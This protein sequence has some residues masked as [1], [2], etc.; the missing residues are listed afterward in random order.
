MKKKIIFLS[1]FILLLAIGGI[2]IFY[3]TQTHRN[4][5][6]FADE[7]KYKTRLVPAPVDG[8]TPVDHNPYDNIAYMLWVLEHTEQYTSHTEGTAVSVGQTQ[9]IYNHRRVNGD[10]Q[11][12]DTIS[13]G[14]VSLGKQKYFL[15]NKV[16]IR[17]YISKK[18]DDITWKTDEPE[19]ITK[20][21]YKERYGWL[22]TQATAYIIC[23][24]TILEISEVTLLDNG[25]Y[26]ITLSL[27]PD[28]WYAPF[29]YQRE[30]K[31]NAS[32]VSKP[33]FSSI[34]I[35]Y[36]FNANW[37]IQ[38]V[39][40]KEKYK[41]TPKVAP[42]PVDCVTNITETFD[43]TTGEFDASA[44][45]FFNQYKDMIPVG[46]SSNSNP[47]EETPL[48]YITGSL[49]G[50]TNKEKTFD[51]TININEK[52]IKGKLLLNIS[53]L[54]SIVVKVS[55]GDLQVVY[56]ND[57]VYVDY[58]SLKLKCNIDEMNQ[59]LQPLLAEIVLGSSASSSQT[60]ALDLNKIMDDL[61]QATV[62]KTEEKIN[63]DL[64]L[65]LMGFSLPLVFDIDLNDD[66][67]DLQSIKS[68]V[69][70]AGTEIKISIDK[71]ENLQFGTIEGEYSDLKN[72]DFILKDITSILKNKKLSLA[73]SADYEDY[74]IS[75]TAKIG[76]HPND[77]I[78]INLTM[79]NEKLGLNESFIITYASSN[80]F[81]EYK[82][83]KLKLSMTD[84]IPWIKKYLP[85]AKM[86][87][88]NVD[89]V[90][91]ILSNIDFKA[92]IQQFTIQENEVSIALDLSSLIEELSIINLLAEDT[93][94]G[95]VLKT[96]MYDIVVS[97]DATTDFS[98]EFDSSDYVDMESY[99]DLVDYV[100]N[101]LGKESLGI[102]I[103]GTL[104]YDTYTIHL[105]GDINLYLKDTAYTVEGSIVVSYLDKEVEVKLIVED[106]D[107]YVSVLGY[108]IKVNLD[109]ISTTLEEITRRLGVELPKVETPEFGLE[110]ILKLLS[111]VKLDSTSVEMDLSSIFE[112]IGIVGVSYSLE[113][114]SLDVEI[115][116]SLV[117]MRGTIRPIEYKEVKVPTE[118]Y[119]EED[120][121]NVMNYVED[122]LR[123]LKN[124]YATLSFSGVYEGVEVSGSLYV[125]WKDEIRAKGR[126]T[127]IYE[128]HSITL[129]I[130]YSNETIYVGYENIKVKI[131]EATIKEFVSGKLPSKKELKVEEILGKVDEVL[132]GLTIRE[133][134]ISVVL[135]LG[136]ILEGMNEAH[137]ELK[138]T[139]AG[140]DITTDLY[141]F[142]LS[143]DVNQEDSVEVEDSEYTK[144]EGYIDLV[145]YFMSILCKES[146]GI[147]ID[148]TLTYDT[149]T[150]H[151]LGDINL[152]LKDT[153]YTVEG[154]IVVSYLDKEVEVK[155]IVED[156]DVYVSVLGYTIKVNLDTISTTLEEITRR[157]GVELPKVETPE[158]GLEEIL[159]LLSTVKLDSTSVEMDL[160]SIFEM[161]G[162]VGVS[163]SLEGTSLDVEIRNSLVSMRGTIRPIEYKEVKVPTEYYDEEDILNVMN[164]VEDILRLL[165]NQYAT[166]SFSGVYEGVEVSGSLYVEWKD[167]IRAKGRITVIY[168]GHSITLDIV[169][170]NETIYVG[171]ENIKVKISEAT[172]KEFVSG[173]LPSK[174]ELKVEEILGKVDEVLKGL[175]IRED[176]ISVVLNL[177]AILEGMNEAHIELKDTEAGF[178][179]TTDLY[180]FSL[181]VDVNQEDSVEVEDSEYTKVEG[182]IDLVEY[183]MS[184]L[185]KESLGIHID[186][187]YYLEGMPVE[188]NGML[189]LMYNT[190]T[191]RYDISINLTLEVSDILAQMK[192]YFVDNTLYIEFY[193]NVIEISASEL[194]EVIAV[195][196]EKFNLPLDNAST[197]LPIDQILEL[198]KSIYFFENSMEFDFSSYIA[199]LTKLVFVYT[200]IDDGYEFVVK[201][202]DLFDVA[203]TLGTIPYE[204]IVTPKA[205]LYKEDLYIL[206]DDISYILELVQGNAIQIE[207]PDALIKITMNGQEE[208]IKVNGTV[209]VLW[210]EEGYQISGSL[211]LDGMGI[212]AQIGIIVLNDTIY[213][214]VSN[215]TFC[216]KLNEIQDFISE[217]LE[218]LSPML[219]IAMPSMEASSFSLDMKDLG[220][221]L[222][223]RSIEA[224]LEAIVGNACAFLVSF[225]LVENGMITQISISYDD[226]VQFESPILISKSDVQQIDVPTYSLDKDAILEILTYAVEAYELSLKDEFNLAISTS[227]HT[228]GDVV[229]NIS[230]NVYIKLLENQE[231]DAHL[232]LIVYEYNQGNEV[233]WHQL[234]L[235][236]ISLTTMNTL[237]PSVGTAMM[238]GIYG[239][240]PN[241]LNAVVKVKSTY[242]GIEDLIAS[243]MQLMN[244][245]IPALSG[246]TTTSRMDI[247]SLIDYLEVA[248][249]SLSIGIE[250]NNLFA[251]MQDERQIIH[252]TLSKDT[253]S[254]LEGILVDNLYVSYTN[255]A[256]YM[257][258]DSLQVNLQNKEVNF[259]I[260]SADELAS[261]YDISEISNLFEALYY[262]ALE[263]NYEISGT[264]TLTALSI[265]N[266][267]MP[268]LFKIQ[269]DENG[270]PI[271]YA[272]LDMTNIGLGSLMMTKKHIY[273]YYKDSYVYIHRDDAK[274]ENDRKIKIHISEFMDNIVYYLMDYAMGLPESIISLINKTPE[275]DGF[276]DAAQCINNIFIGEDQFE[277]DLNLKEIAD[278][279]NL[280]KLLIR[281]A[282]VLV[283]KTD[284]EG[285]KIYV[286]MIYQIPKFEF[287]A[288]DVVNLN[289]SS[290]TLS[291]IK[292]DESGDYIAYDITLDELDSYLADFN[293]FYN[294]DEEYIYSKGAWVSNG[295]IKHNVVYSLGAIEDKVKRYAEGDLLDFPSYKDDIITVDVDG[296]TQYYKIL[297]WYEDAS[298]L[299]PVESI[300]NV[301]MGN[302]ARVF[303]AKLK[304]ITV[305]LTIASALDEEVILTYYEGY[306]FVREIESMYSIHK[307]E[308]RIYKFVGIQDESN[309]L[310][311]VN[312]LTYGNY[313]LTVAWD[314]VHYDFYAVYDGNEK[315]LEDTSEEVFLNQDYSIFYNG[316]Y[317]LYQNTYLTPQVLLSKF[318]NAFAVNEDEERFEIELYSKENTLFE[319]YD[320]VLFTTTREE[321]NS[322]DYYG[323]YIEKNKETDVSSLLPNGVWETF[324]INAWIEDTTYYSLDDI[325]HMTG[326]HTFTSYISTQLSYFDFE[327]VSTGASI[328]G[329]TGTSSTVIF[330]EYA[331]LSGYYRKVVEIK[332]LLDSNQN[333][334]S[335]FTENTTISTLIMNESLAFIGRNAFKNCDGL[336]N[337]Y[338]PSALEASSVASDAF[339]F[340]KTGT[341]NFEKARDI[342]KEITFHC[343]LKQA[344]ELDL[345]ACTYNGSD[346][347]YGKNEAGFLG[348]G[349]ANL[350]NSFA[351]ETICIADISNE[352]IKNM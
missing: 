296:T 138:D 282:S 128:G 103:D 61:N 124:Q 80:I 17:D 190:T 216:F 226:T 184:I 280:G 18:G 161:I 339:Y 327:I 247:R 275:G 23:E 48:S 286:P 228:N 152:Y 162:I 56:E 85:E 349:R 238:Y 256:Q 204:K 193:E 169:Y 312:A 224:S 336:A 131:S 316:V 310:I 6:V 153:V 170:S 302:K 277:F 298:Y 340:V 144:V 206:L 254:K 326:T 242:K 149:Y 263:K 177:G 35:E 295:K 139:E 68:N 50:G 240:N 111:T 8:T 119:D 186:G 86:P 274:N 252:I 96:N 148:G 9:T 130:V 120:I 63:L 29:W 106:K 164:Y 233:A 158:F 304:E 182:Y 210:S 251:A 299:K 231:F 3:Y 260:P 11:L 129:D 87:E 178:D 290:L 191:L 44:M 82:D 335:A 303:Y 337:V 174:K 264:V 331:L 105:L 346:R 24:E 57:Q 53:N 47:E 267:N 271:V 201:Q 52:P 235:Q 330:P 253:E 285:N 348:A 344:S 241:D 165:K 159:K 77:P 79:D 4:D 118:Y 289:S 156:K 243:I 281:L 127:V 209:D 76:L 172:I 34:V 26:S 137:I 187:T 244:L 222:T 134:K 259:T 317:Y 171:Y 219:N 255:T 99:L 69:S 13:S 350:T 91:E 125:E 90:L 22:P 42:I 273:I 1:I 314:E 114:T 15:D 351:K 284:E 173:K 157:L 213:I 246:E 203:F 189:E 49:L 217:A 150:I 112:M 225:S 78:Q 12:V 261:Y 227:I 205:S 62:I 334:Y 325:K 163:Y 324:E 145:E 45:E 181:S 54:T 230:G 198:T 214:T 160:S 132:K 320:I 311:D 28:E 272:H 266:V 292:Q 194:D 72:I 143:V 192:V 117:S 301:Y 31:T 200:K 10:E 46:D 107:V 291:N 5:V 328:T 151:L 297:G 232:D 236:I 41:V 197:E 293:A 333:V 342:A 93:E 94:S 88:V 229:A 212:L 211:L 83:M 180:D 60:E 265:V 16:L 27:N 51:I 74:S 199:V 64:T 122:I 135:N 268:V 239:N 123:L 319:A 249:H 100:T 121:L 318:G 146:L 2:G 176:K 55:L 110:E 43:Y 308:D 309:A 218:I 341:M 168:E 287:V 347:H 141:D 136:A 66:K 307:L 208:S 20:D 332:E 39:N 262:N 245:D 7:A 257:K 321:F 288:V 65:D 315:L 207:I 142:S 258:L 179:I 167:E 81:V 294:A 19:C 154:S 223:S 98:T 95:F 279:N 215:Q 221:L 237:D 248:D 343:S 33:V 97:V 116:N 58:G 323:F 220:L 75:G 250:A 283:A 188:F 313:F 155:L 32:S 70:L 102:H 329:Y 37:Q 338:L 59:I 202:N 306:D 234:D 278:N 109:T 92:L 101:Y 67:L 25:L 183:F 185:C 140:F 40:T 195:L 73:F 30:V 270:A 89:Q 104:T 300:H 269:V 113:G 196:C 345:V 71:N 38:Q 175:T 14:L 21:A 276:V 352:V 36:I 322:K 126:I 133:D 84:F 147:H 166:L 305:S 108:T 115:R